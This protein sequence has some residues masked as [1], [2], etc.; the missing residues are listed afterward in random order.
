MFPESEVRTLWSMFKRSAAGA[1][2]LLGTACSPDLP[3]ALSPVSLELS[4]SRTLSGS[5]EMV[6]SSFVGSGAL[7]Q[8]QIAAFS[9]VSSGRTFRAH[10]PGARVQIGVAHVFGDRVGIEQP[11]ALSGEARQSSKVTDEAG[12]VHD[13]VYEKSALTGL[14]VRMTHHVAGELLAVTEYHWKTV[15]GGAV[16]ESQRLSVYKGGVIQRTVTIATKDVE[17]TLDVGSLFREVTPSSVLSVFLPR[18]AFASDLT[19]T[20]TEVD[21]A[22]CFAEGL[23]VAAAGVAMAVECVAGGPINPLCIAAT[24]GYIAAA[25]SWRKCRQEPE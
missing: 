17:S 1:A 10:L 16:L 12:R 4:Q 8:R 11:T 6:D 18:K 23:A 2:V 13:F 20:A 22:G 9:T 7:V 15:L 25:E 3:T 21:E 19:A 14:P 5:L 24:L